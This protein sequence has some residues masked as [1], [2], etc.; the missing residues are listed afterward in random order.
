MALSCILASLS[1]LSQAVELPVASLSLMYRYEA[2]DV[3]LT[4]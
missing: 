2:Y 3:L 1:L 4:T